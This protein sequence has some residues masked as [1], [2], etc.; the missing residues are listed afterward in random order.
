MIYF[1]KLTIPCHY[2]HTISGTTLCDYLELRKGF[3]KYVKLTSLARNMRAGEKRP[4]VLK[5]A[6]LSEESSVSP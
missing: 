3:Q 4:S 5:G 6:L 1:G 2:L